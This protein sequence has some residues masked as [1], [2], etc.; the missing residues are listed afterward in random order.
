MRGLFFVSCL[1]EIKKEGT[2]DSFKLGI[3]VLVFQLSKFRN[4]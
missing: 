3:T 1:P 2:K 4:F